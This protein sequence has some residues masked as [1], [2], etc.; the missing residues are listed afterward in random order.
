[1]N[2]LINELIKKWINEEAPEATGSPV[3]KQ[4]LLWL[5]NFIFF[6]N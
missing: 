1:M 2:K 4:H 6:F 5:Y 3:H